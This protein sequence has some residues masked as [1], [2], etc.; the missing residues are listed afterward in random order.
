M[1]K[2]QS[3]LD[4]KDIGRRLSHEFDGHK[5]TVE[6]VDVKIGYGRKRFFVKVLD[7]IWI[8]APKG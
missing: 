3:G 7:Q 5:V 4:K 8:N 6:V 1:K 2:E